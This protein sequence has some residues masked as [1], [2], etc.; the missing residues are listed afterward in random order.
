MSE[1][2]KYLKR[3]SAY[4]EDAPDGTVVI[5][6]QHLLRQYNELRGQGWTR[7]WSGEGRICMRPP[8]AA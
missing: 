3:G 5:W 7:V 8:A 6:G 2:T 1:S 4:R